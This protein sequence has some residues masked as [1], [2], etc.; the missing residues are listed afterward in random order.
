MVFSS[1]NFL[2]LFLPVVFIIYYLSPSINIK[3]YIILIASILFYAFGEPVYVFLIIGGSYVNYKM[4]LIMENTF[5][6]KQVFWSLIVFNL[7]ILIFFKYFQDFTKLSMPLGISFYT[8]QSVS[9][10]IDCY[11]GETS[12]QK[13]FSHM[14]LYISFFPQLIAGPIVKYHDFQYQIE[15]RTTDIKRICDGLSRFILGLSKKV[16]IANTLSYIVDEIYSFNGTDQN[17]L[18]LWIAA[19]L[20]ALQIYFDFSGYS[21]MALGLSKAFGFV[22][23]ENFDRP[24]SSRSIKEFWRR[25]HISL[26]T[27]FKE[28]VYIPLGGNRISE[29]RTVI[30]KF[31]VF[32]LTGMWHGAGLNFIVWGM[33]HGTYITLSDKLKFLKK[34]ENKR[35]G[36]VFTFLFVCISFVMFRS[37]DVLTGFGNIFKMFTAVNIT[38]ESMMTLL[39]MFDP[40]NVFIIA[41]SVLCLLSLPKIIY[42]YRYPLTVVSYYL[43][44]MVLSTGG[45]NP[46]I[47][48]RF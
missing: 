34:I 5:K 36:Q 17:I 23:L 4:T 1:I 45:Y 12:A 46:F 33:M 14:L 30:N 11:R 22:L 19:I 44:V 35:I 39:L 47:Y 28:Y 32:F 31:T 2:L 13:R 37:T 42:K 9:Y 16:L 25:W 24:F 20:Y 18:S 41:V 29:K 48:F 3:N 7:A 43:C 15:N 27:W 26:S 8:F 21:D 10:I 38:K 40:Y 6:K